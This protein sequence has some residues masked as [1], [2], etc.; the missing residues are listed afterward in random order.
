[1][2][3]V[4]TG[5][6]DAGA[7][8]LPPSPAAT[9]WM[10]G[11][12]ALVLAVAVA[13]R[14]QALAWDTLHG[15]LGLQ[16][17]LSRLTA[18]GAVP[19]RDFEHGWNALGW[20]AGAAL[21]RVVG[22][23]ATWW[24]FAWLHVTAELLAGLAILAV[25]WR[26]RLRPGWILGLF[27]TWM[28]LTTVVNGKYAI[29][30]LWLL[31]LLPV[32]VAAR[33][34]LAVAARVAVA[35]LTFWAHVDLAIMLTGGV[36]L[37]DLLGERA[38]AWRDRLI[39][40]AAAPAGLVAALAVQAVVYARLGIAPADLVG[41]LLLA[42]GATVEGINFGYPLLQPV[43]LRMLIYPVSLLVPL[44]P[45]VWSRLTDPTRLAALLHLSM[46]LTVIRKPDQPHLA[47]AATLL[48]VVAVLAVRDLLAERRP[49][50]AAERHAGAL[51]RALLGAAWFAAAVAVGFT[52]D[53]LLAAAGLVTLGMIGPLLAVRGE[54]AWGSLGALAAAAVL[55][56][57]A[58]GGHMAGQLP[59]AEDDRKARLIAAEAKPAVDACLGDGHEAWVVPEPAGLY[60][61]L[62]VVNPTPFYLFWAG[63]AA[64]TDRVVVM[65]D[66]GEIPAVIQVNDW[67]PVAFDALAPAIAARY[68]R[69]AEVTVP[70]TGDRVTVWTH[71]G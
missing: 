15:D 56:A 33:G 66:A 62:G 4:E 44:V 18:E 12:S 30:S 40:A 9:R 52:W 1:V 17:H 45:V 26:L 2:T 37:Y 39:R 59:A 8:P 67:P 11:L 21:Y 65:M 20:V 16:Y 61:Y 48:A 13:L 24:M 49:W 28:W 29:P 36:V 54:Q 31:A 27:A 55:L 46:C 3:I 41:F 14:F 70:A 63:F 19:I 38:P 22:G 6:A 71:R 35:A 69:C 51:P 5:R 64:E 58:A 42:R 32:G 47:A 53:H 43:G 34:R 7:R 68:D 10:L 57:A 25:A 23:N 60:R 50:L